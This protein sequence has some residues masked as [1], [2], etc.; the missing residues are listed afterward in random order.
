MVTQLPADHRAFLLVV[1]AQVVRAALVRQAR[2]MPPP[3]IGSGFRQERDQTMIEG[4]ALNRRVPSTVAAGTAWPQ[5]ASGV[6]AMASPV[7]HKMLLLPTARHCESR[8]GSPV[9]SERAH[10]SVA[11][12]LPCRVLK[13]L[14][15]CERH[16][17]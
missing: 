2:G 14:Q 12:S 15:G 6:S 7:A 16:V 1:E 8:P 11:T 4:L 9:R 5:P 10:G 3:C 17:F 13:A